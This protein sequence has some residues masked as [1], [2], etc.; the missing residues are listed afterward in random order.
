MG[1]ILMEI[2]TWKE[3]DFETWKKV[4]NEIIEK[5]KSDLVRYELLK[6][7]PDKDLKNYYTQKY[8]S[9]KTDWINNLE[10]LTTGTKFKDI[11]K[12]YLD[13]DGLPV[14]KQLGPTLI[15]MYNKQVD[16]INKSYI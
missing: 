14:L 4:L 12:F 5:Q 13:E 11:S 16:E 7:T 1:E 9:I 10:L 2:P 8:Q 3:V 6:N 15:K